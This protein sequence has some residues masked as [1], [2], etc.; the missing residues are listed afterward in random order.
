M[1]SFITE[2][3]SF[4]RWLLVS[5]MQVSVLVCLIFVIKAVIR[6]RLAVRWHYWL[7]LLLLV[8]MVS[9]WVPESSFS[10]FTLTSQAQRAVV[11]EHIAK[12]AAKLNPNIE[13]RNTNQIQTTNIQMTETKI[14]AAARLPDTTPTKLISAQAPAGTS[15]FSLGVIDVLS[16]IWFTVA[17]GLA[18]FALMCNFRLWRI[19]KSQRPLTEGKI[20][21]LL[22]DCKAEMGVQTI[23]GVIV[24]DKVKSPALFGVVRPRLLLPEGIIKTL[25]TEQLRYVFLHELAHLKR[26]DIYLGWLM[27]ILQILHWFNPLVWLAF[28]RMRADR[29]LACDGLV[30]STMDT[31]QSQAYGR[32][33]VNLFKGFSRPRFVP[34]IAGILENKSLLKRRIT[35]IARFKK[36]SYRWSALAVVLLAVLAC[37]A[38]TNARAASQA[39]SKEPTILA[40]EFVELLVEGQ[41][42]KATENFDATMKKSLP[43][44]KLAETW[45]STTGQAGLFKQQLGVREE[46]FLGSDIVLVTCEFEKGPLDV[47]VV[48]NSERKVSGLWFLPVPEA[49]LKS[50]QGQ[51]KQPAGDTTQ[52]ESKESRQRD[53]VRVVVSKDKITFQGK[54]LDNWEQ[55]GLLLPQV[56]NRKQTVLEVAVTSTDIREGQDWDRI[57]ALL[58]SWANEY[59][60][61]YLSFIGEHPLGSYGISESRFGERFH[62]AVTVDIE[63]SPNNEPLTVQYAVM[64][65]CKDAGIP[66]QWEKSAELA[67]PQRRNFTEP[68]HT[69]DVPL[70]KVLLDVLTPVGLRYDLDENGLYL[71]R[72][73]NQKALKDH[74]AEMRGS[75]ET[76]TATTSRQR[77]KS[78]ELSYDDGASGGRKSIAG[79]GHAVIFEAPAEGC[80]L[81]AVRI[82]GSRYGHPGAPRE[83]FHIWLCDKDFNVIEDFPFPYARFMRGNPRW[84]TLRVKDIEVPSTFVICAGFDPEQTKGVYVHYDDSGSGNSFT[85]LPGKE[86]PVFNEGEWMIR[87]VVQQGESESQTTVEAEQ[88]K[89]IGATAKA[90]S[91]QSLID[92]AQSNG[93]VIIPDGLYTEP[94]EITKPLTLKGQSRVNC[95]FEVTANKPA[96]F[97]DTKGKGRVTIE[98]ITIKWQLATSD[99]NI[100]YPFALGVKDSKV[101][102]KNC[103]FEPLG[104]FER[105]PV[106]VRSVGFSK[107]DIDNS[108]F[109]GFEYVICYGEGTEGAVRDCLIVGCGHQGVILYSGAKAQIVRNVI[110]GSGYHAVRSTGGD[111]Q[112]MDNLIINNA[113]RGVYLGN[114]SAKGTISNNIIMGNGTGISGFARSRVIIENNIIADNSYAGIGF[115]N[116][117]G[118]QIRNNIFRGNQRGWV[119]FKEGDRNNNGC[120]RNTFWQN[121]VDAENFQKTANSI[122]ADPGF[123]DP[124]NG[125]FS[126]RAGPALEHE[127]GLTNPEILKMLWKRWQKRED[128]N[129][130]FTNSGHSG[131]QPRTVK[132]GDTTKADKMEAENLTA[133]GWQLWGQRQLVE[134][135]AKFKNAIAKDPQAEGAYQG[136]GW[137]QLNQGKRLNAKDSFKKCI[138]INPKNSAAL[139]GLGWI[140]HGQ[141]DKDEAI[142]WWEK[143][144]DAS[145]GYATASL[146]GLTQVYMQKKEYDSAIKYYQMWLKVEP[147]NEQVKMKLQEAQIL[148][149]GDT[150][151]AKEFQETMIKKLIKEMYEPI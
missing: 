44:D 45:R 26:H 146:N 141:G 25:S 138:A 119:M 73:V 151:A 34:G 90:G 19:I 17:L 97:V 115:R 23:L 57:M 109:E 46:K 149:G 40:K 104:N 91:L 111:L 140:A 110:T 24:T 16:L 10:V 12:A 106:A 144:V 74:R 15:T 7:W 131:T 65:I 68:L 136:L 123:T 63:Q 32:T 92:S 129:E 113:N 8:R 76:A 42:S 117:C 81:K 79:G 5:T 55:L 56:P 137:A 18:I 22:E 1:E 105:S 95:I 77:R 3:S 38:L 66:Y 114:K 14:P 83:D 93:T 118:L 127:Q 49:V 2:L 142:S 29:E 86:M 70:E 126:L 88:A 85:G 47:K 31:G 61:E 62:N 101:E 43:A 150:G 21:D 116:S 108:R 125:D 36:G 112:M 69:E 143:A 132:A 134:A 128:K 59:G 100:E 28:A 130:P 9:P 107:L 99:K 41:F 60:F 64:A 35:M 89:E 53:F 148:A 94:I 11:P 37:V 133:E 80:I 6:R 98:G 51:Q 72:P 124:E 4:F 145:N 147:D 48:Y 96:I 120:Q 82:Y 39:E 30:L 54:E 135:E 13:I 20:L 84:V 52:A 67:D 78:V 87:A 122:E 27:V 75:T 139:N 50:Y 121:E 58:G 33:L 103:C 102:I 71:Y